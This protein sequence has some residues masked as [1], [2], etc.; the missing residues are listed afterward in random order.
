MSTKPLHSSF[1]NPFPPHTGSFT[2]QRQSLQKRNTPAPSSGSDTQKSPGNAAGRVELRQ[3]GLEGGNSQLVQEPRHSV[4]QEG[5]VRGLAL[6]CGPQ[7]LP[8][9]DK[10]EG[11]DQMTQVHWPS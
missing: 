8:S 7:T 6:A 3:E 10:R 2:A 5:A 9:R 11:A 1:Y 4:S